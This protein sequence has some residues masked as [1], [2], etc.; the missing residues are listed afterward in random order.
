MRD[1][2]ASVHPGENTGRASCPRQMA[3]G[4]EAAERKTSGAAA[5][6]PA[7][8][9]SALSVLLYGGY[10]EAIGGINANSPFTLRRFCVTAAVHACRDSRSCAVLLGSF[11]VLFVQRSLH[12]SS[13]NGIRMACESSKMHAAILL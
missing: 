8:K 6:P 7:G 10:A 5:C 13:R 2:W 3:R 9:N 12:G 1:L 11:R 4:G